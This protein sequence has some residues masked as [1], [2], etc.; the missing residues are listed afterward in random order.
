MPLIHWAKHRNT[1]QPTCFP[2]PW[3]LMFAKGLVETHSLDDFGVNPLLQSAFPEISLTSKGLWISSSARTWTKTPGSVPMWRQERSLLLRRFDF[4]GAPL[5][6]VVDVHIY[7]YIYI[8]IWY[9][10][11]SPPPPP[12]PPHQWSR[13]RQVPPPPPVWLWSCGWVVV[14]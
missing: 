5:V 11:A 9:S 8:Y 13:V 12:P 10:V 3:T 1:L 7:I 4:S 6:R 14:V 2:G